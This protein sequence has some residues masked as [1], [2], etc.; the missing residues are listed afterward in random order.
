MGGNRVDAGK[1]DE[2]FTM[3]VCSRSFLVYAFKFALSQLFSVRDGDIQGQ[4]VGGGCDGRVDEGDEKK[5]R[6][7]FGRGNQISRIYLIVTCTEKI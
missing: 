6:G 3:S 1:C 7:L 4:V 2:H 5:G